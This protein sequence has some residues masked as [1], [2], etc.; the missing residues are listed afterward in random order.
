MR[1]KIGKGAE[2]IHSKKVAGVIG[3]DLFTVED[4]DES[5]DSFEDLNNEGAKNLL[6]DG[7]EDPS[8]LIDLELVN[9]LRYC[10][11]LCAHKE[12]E[13]YEDEIMLKSI[14]LGMKTKDKLL[15]FDMD[16]TL[17][18]AKFEGHIPEGFDPTFTFMLKGSQI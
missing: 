4:S 14:S 10:H 12:T 2:K 3:H 11:E 9:L 5:A 18:A 6:M 17:V 16:E 1:N 8:N 15:I 13:E 7:G